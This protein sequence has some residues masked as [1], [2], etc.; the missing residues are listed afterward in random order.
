MPDYWG[1]T[2]PDLSSIY[3]DANIPAS[4]AQNPNPQAVASTKQVTWEQEVAMREAVQDAYRTVAEQYM[5]T[6]LRTAL[7]AGDASKATALPAWFPPNPYTTD[8]DAMRRW[9]AA[10]Q[11]NPEVVANWNT[12]K[13][14][15]DALNPNTNPAAP[16]AQPLLPRPTNAP[17]GFE[18]MANGMLYNAATGQ[19]ATYDG[20]ILPMSVSKGPDGAIRRVA[21]PTPMS[22]TPGGFAGAQQNPNQMQ[23]PQGPV[24]HQAFGAPPNGTPASWS[25]PPATS[26]VVPPTATGRPD[27]GIPGGEVPT[28]TVPALKTAAGTPIPEKPAPARVPGTAY[29]GG[30]PIPAAILDLQAKMQ[31]WGADGVVT[32]AEQEE[33]H[34]LVN[35]QFGGPGGM[36]RQMTGRTTHGTAPNALA[37]SGP[38]IY[39]YA[40]ENAIAATLADRARNGISY[41]S[42]GLPPAAS[43]SQTMY[44]NAVMPGK[45]AGMVRPGFTNPLRTNGG[46][47][48]DPMK[49]K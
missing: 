31:K 19:I 11:G 24:T 48:T 35:T 40:Q 47:V 26:P 27:M 32:P 34:N 29:T 17:E 28:N 15:F 3:R 12:L 30:K 9:L 37:K 39:N 44:D 6:A 14:I 22:V 42:V 45:I 13:P 23:A 4:T 36:F 2:S 7:K 38:P 5:Q 18:V 41:D 43:Q 8:P 49:I 20:E 46:V 10:N 33:F 1:G 21:S 16:A 25:Q